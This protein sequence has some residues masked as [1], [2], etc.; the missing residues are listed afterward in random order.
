MSA[1]IWVALRCVMVSA[2]AGLTQPVT[3]TPTASITATNAALH[4]LFIEPTSGSP[5]K[6]SLVI[7]ILERLALSCMRL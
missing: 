4:L 6:F 7:L 5:F 2:D 1:M 3:D